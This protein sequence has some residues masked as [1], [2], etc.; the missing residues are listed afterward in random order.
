[1]GRGPMRAWDTRFDYPAFRRM[2]KRRGITAQSITSILDM[3]LSYISD[4]GLKG[5]IERDALEK[6]CKIIKEDPEEFII[7]D[8]P[9]KNQEVQITTQ[10]YLESI[11]EQIA[12]I[13][14]ELTILKAEFNKENASNLGMIMMLKNFVTTVE[15]AIK[16]VGLNDERSEIQSTES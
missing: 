8:D 11:E 15:D 10:E 14:G 3:P 4:A 6:I 7:P 5:M 9:V 13:R 2:L 16:K 12:D 1:M